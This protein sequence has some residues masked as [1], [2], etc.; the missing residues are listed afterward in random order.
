MSTLNTQSGNRLTLTDNLATPTAAEGLVAMGKYN[1]SAPTYTDG[2]VGFFQLTSDGRLKVDADISVTDIDVEIGSVEIK[3]ATDD[4]RAV[5]RTDGTE[6]ALVVTTNVME[7][8]SALPTGTN[9]IGSVG[10]NDGSEALNIV[11]DD[12]PFSAGMTGTLLMGA[13]TS[14]T[15][16]S[17]DIGALRLTTDRYLQVDVAAIVPG[18]GATNLGKA[19]DAQ[20]AS[21]DVGVMA[22]AVRNDTLAALGATDG[23]YAPLQVNATGALFVQASPGTDYIGKTRRT[24]GTTD[25][26]LPTTAAVASGA[27]GANLLAAGSGTTK[28]K[29]FYCLLSVDTAGTVTLSD[30]M[31]VHYMTA[32]ETIP[33]DFR[34]LGLEQDTADT[35]ITVTNGGGGN[36][37]ASLTYS[38]G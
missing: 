23:D 8:T 30:G 2:D 35:A 29:I 18:T 14:A 10:I 1:S 31:G 4:T 9:L 36:F 27:S 22:L 5:V 6:N 28:H 7:I 20:H 15:I 24:D 38:T 32:G 34:P 3:N 16:G 25:E 21:S 19:E 26:V 12:Q 13:A 33:I 11:R 37:S 17:G